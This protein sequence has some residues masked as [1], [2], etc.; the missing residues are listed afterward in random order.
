MSQSELVHRIFQA[1]GL[2][3][4]TNE[5]PIEQRKQAEV[6]KLWEQ[7]LKDEPLTMETAS[8]LNSSGFISK[9]PWAI[10][11]LAAATLLVGF[12]TLQVMLT[13]PG[14]RLAAFR[15]LPY[16]V[17]TRYVALS[18]EQS[19]DA[20]APSIVAIQG[21]EIRLTRGV[22]KLT[23]DGPDSYTVTSL[24]FEATLNST[25]T[26]RIIVIH[27]LGRSVISGTEMQMDLGMQAG[28]IFT[29]G[30]LSSER[31]GIRPVSLAGPARISLSG[32]G[33]VTLAGKSTIHDPG[34]QAE[35][36]VI[37]QIFEL[38]DGRIF[39]GEVIEGDGAILEIR[40]KEGTQL[41]VARKDL[42]N[43]RIL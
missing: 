1:E 43:S 16:F 21:G 25:R 17:R 2:E 19:I 26:S 14:S 24:D 33:F 42:K 7:F 28:Q 39:T 40:T 29:N 20:A 32:E 6:E 27:P 10:A 35:S 9:A 22:A 13:E 15:T 23:T 37:L 18:P 12:F 41:K 5:T 36:I 11:G 38:R 8:P 34:P 4:R 3:D 30:D 31:K